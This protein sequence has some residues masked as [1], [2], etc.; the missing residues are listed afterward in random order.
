MFAAI[1]KQLALILL[2]AAVAL[3][4]IAA[5]AQSSGGSGGGSS[6][7]G[8]SAGS[9]GGGSVGGGAAG[10]GTGSRSTGRS[11]GG[12][13]ATIP[14]TPNTNPNGFRNN[15]S[16]T[17]TPGL[18]TPAQENTRQ[19]AMDLRNSEPSTSQPTTPGD[20]RGRTSDVGQEDEQP[21]PNSGAL[22]ER[23]S[24]GR[25]TD[26]NELSAGGSSRQG[27][28]GRTMAECEGAWDAQTHMSKEKWRETCRRTLTD[29]HL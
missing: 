26:V 5:I 18:R 13:S 15:A 23:V 20:T 7:G 29:P 22:P 9:A 11:L 3:F 1:T 24:P 14:G 27:A 28:V 25:S 19:R 12:S 10:R 21:S 2:Y 8:S 17:T 16:P 6:G 4:P